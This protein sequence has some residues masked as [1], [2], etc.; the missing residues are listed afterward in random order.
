MSKKSKRAIS[1]LGILLSLAY[2]LIVIIF[3]VTSSEKFLTFMEILTI[4]SAPLFL[5]F[6]LTI[7]SD[8]NKDKN[9]LKHSALIAISGCIMLTVIAHFVN[10]TITRPLIAECINVPL[11][12]Q[13]GQWP[14]VEMS[15][16]YLAWGL[17]LGT[18]FICTALTIPKNRNNAIKTTLL[19]CGLLCLIGFMGPVIGAIDIWYIAVMGYIVGFVILC[20]MQIVFNRE[21]ERTK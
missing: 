16:D 9:A 6:L 8:T 7:L 11:Y 4:I 5:L 17:F 10:L 14:S 3:I 2:L 15:L 12:F 21:K 20:V 18:A 13:I 19:I 1:Y